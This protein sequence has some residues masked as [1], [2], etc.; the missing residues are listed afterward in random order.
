MHK[1]QCLFSA[2]CYVLIFVSVLLGLPFG[3]YT[4]RV[5]I[6]CIYYFVFTISLY[7]MHYINLSR[8]LAASV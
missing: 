8:Y 5:T 1:F 2:I 7:F 3:V 6:S 4:I